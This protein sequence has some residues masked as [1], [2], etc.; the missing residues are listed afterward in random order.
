MDLYRWVP[1]CPPRTGVSFLFRSNLRLPREVLTFCVF[2]PATGTVTPPKGTAVSAVPS[3]MSTA[4]PPGVPEYNW[5]QCQNDAASMAHNN[6][7]LTFD[8]PSGTGE[9]FSRKDLMKL[10][11]GQ[12]SQL[13]IFQAV[14]WC[15]QIRCR[16]KSIHQL[17]RAPTL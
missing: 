9:F 6:Q 1:P 4:A 11:P 14:A 12:I 7:Q 2:K 15:W 16:D 13:E 8:N 10:T 17:L 3:G 5:R